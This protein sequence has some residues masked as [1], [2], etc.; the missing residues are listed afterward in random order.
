[1]CSSDLIAV[2]L[3]PQS[4]LVERFFDR[5][6]PEKLF[7]LEQINKADNLQKAMDNY[8]KCLEKINSKEVYKK[9]ANSGFYTIVREDNSTIEI[10]INKLTIHFGL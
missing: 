1:M 10:T 3:C 4:M 7:I 5:S 2:M 8:R 9:Y 6:D